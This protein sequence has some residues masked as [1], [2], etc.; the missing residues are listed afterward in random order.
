VGIIFSKSKPGSSCSSRDCNFARFSFSA[1][2]F[3]ASMTGTDQGIIRRFTALLQ[4]QEILLKSMHLKPQN[5]LLQNNPCF[6]CR[7]MTIKL[8]FAKLKI[9]NSAVLPIGTDI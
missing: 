4:G 9:V 7:I 1:S 3:A 6:A 8:L 2:E 5:C